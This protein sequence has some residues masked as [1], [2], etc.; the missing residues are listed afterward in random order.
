[1]KILA[2]WLALSACAAAQ[3]QPPGSANVSDAV[4]T[5]T[6]TLYA[7]GLVGISASGSSTSSPSQQYFAEFNLITPLNCFQRN[8]VHP[9]QHKCW[10]WLNPRI[11]SVPSG[12]ATALSTLSSSLAALP[13]GLSGQTIQQITQSLEFQGGVEYY[14]KSPWEGAQLEGI[15]AGGELALR[16]SPAEES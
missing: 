13:G 8:I 2:A 1:M 4:P 3:T 9:L 16:S 15:A 7:L 5:S 11:A 14:F 6:S 10:M 12:S